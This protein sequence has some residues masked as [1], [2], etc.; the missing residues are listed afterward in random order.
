MG[1]TEALSREPSP[2]DLSASDVERLARDP[3]W[4][5]QIQYRKTLFSGYE[6][7]ADGPWFFLSPEGRTSPEAEL[8]ATYEML[9]DSPETK[10]GYISQPVICAF[11]TRKNFLE[12][13]LG[14]RFRD[15]ACKERDEWL[16][17][18]KGTRLYLVFSDA[19]PNNPAS[20]FG[21]TFILLS[22]NRPPDSAAGLL[23][24]AFNFS[25]D[26]AGTNEK[27]LF[28]SIR[29][30]FGGF[31]GRYRINPFYLMI[32]QYVK[33]DSR[34]LWYLEVP[35]DQ[36]KVSRFLDHVWEIFTTTHFDYYFFDE[37]CSYRLLAAMDYADPNLHLIDEFTYRGP[38]YYVSP[39]ATYRALKSRYGITSEHYT[40][41]IQKSL[42]LRIQNLSR[43]Q[44]K[45]FRQLRNNTNLIDAE[46]DVQ[47]LDALIAFF[48]YKK[49]MSGSNALP[50]KVTVGLRKALSTRAKLGVPSPPD[51]I[52][53][54][55]SSPDKGHGNH[56]VFFGAGR[57]NPSNHDGKTYFVVRAKPGYHDLL[58]PYAGYSKWSHI[59]LLDLQVSISQSAQRV[60]FFNIADLISFFPVNALEVKPSWRAATGYDRNRNWFGLAGVGV[61]WL[62]AKEASLLYFFVSPTV[63]NGNRY[64][65][66]KPYYLE[67]EF[68][69]AIDF[70]SLGRLWLRYV[71][72]WSV[73]GTSRDRQ[74]L[75]RTLADF[76]IQLNT[77]D[78]MRVSGV[79][80]SDE[81]S[82]TLGWAR[83]F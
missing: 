27:S 76:S 15:V 34:D 37:N 57:G 55:P 72:S 64:S 24:Y 41:S 11:P 78:E 71:D 52:V 22:K 80:A 65:D 1:G 79:S 5:G 83:N 14:I 44:A 7:Q 4:L 48:D 32:N 21:H 49:R 70:A 68:G 17:A 67:S 29:G 31:P 18:F 16:E 6:S 42:H 61:S 23:D 35:W 36:V 50:E 12:A 66:Q 75:D 58:S 82:L 54:R 39:V 81:N 25:A 26:T 40:P 19:F 2:A 63:T 3:I 9:R 74:H 30:L 73:S 77:S 56:S 13:N 10:W 28:Y 46:R 60:D 33:W 8:K 51:P 20:M 53:P 69:V 62:G 59:N 43:E 38:F 45:R 47:T